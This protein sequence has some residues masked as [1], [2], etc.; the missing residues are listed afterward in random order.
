MI[1]LILPLYFPASLNNFQHPTLKTIRDSLGLFFLFLAKTTTS[2][3]KDYSDGQ[4][5]KLCYVNNRLSISPSGLLAVNILVST[6]VIVIYLITTDQPKSRALLRRFT[7]I[8]QK[9][10]ILNVSNTFVLDPLSECFI[11]S[12]FTA[13]IVF[14]NMINSMSIF[15]SGLQ[16]WGHLKTSKPFSLSSWSL[17]H[18]F[19]LQRARQGRFM[20]ILLSCKDLK[21]LW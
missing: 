1:Y 9:T 8:L 19:W 7:L 10:K 15:I 11:G 20:L 2:G 13:I 16:L 12:P 4:H 17:S 6:S 3:S 18:L 14:R 21:L 5:S